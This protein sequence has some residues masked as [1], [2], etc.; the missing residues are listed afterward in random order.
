MFGMKIKKFTHYDKQQND[1]CE[2]VLVLVCFIH[3]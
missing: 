2:L 1:M 3:V